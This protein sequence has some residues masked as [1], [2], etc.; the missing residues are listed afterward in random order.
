[1][2]PLPEHETTIPFGAIIDKLQINGDSVTFEYLTE[3]YGCKRD[4]LQ[5]AIVLPKDGDAEPEQ[6]ATTSGAAA[7]PVAAAEPAK[8]QFEA[9]SS[10]VRLS[11][12]K[13]PGGWLLATPQGSVSFYPDPS[14]EWNGES[15]E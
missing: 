12:A 10:T 4:A 14:H 15:V 13:V 11:R 6:A 1:M 8:L 2:N 7:A 9:L 5:G 3:L